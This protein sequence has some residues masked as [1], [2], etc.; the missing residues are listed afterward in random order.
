MKV[1]DDYDVVAVDGEGTYI[2]DGER[3]WQIGGHVDDP[4]DKLQRDYKQAIE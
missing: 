3:Y 2:T 1:L 4:S